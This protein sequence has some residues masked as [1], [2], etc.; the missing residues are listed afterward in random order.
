M[1]N[2]EHSSPV[3]PHSRED[4]AVSRR[5]VF[6]SALGGL[7]AIGLL[8][9]WQDPFSSTMGSSQQPNNLV[10][11]SMASPEVSRQTDTSVSSPGASPVALGGSEDRIGEIEV[12]R[13]ERFQY[14]MAPTDSDTLSV[15]ISG[16]TENLNF[17]PSAVRQDPQIT[18]SYLDPLVWID[19]VTMEP[20]P[21]LAESWEWSDDS[22]EITF[23]LRDDVRWHDG[24]PLNARDVAF[25]FEVYRDDVDSAVRN[26]FTQMKSAE[27]IDSLTVKIELITPDGNWV[28]NAASQFMFQRKQYVAHWESQAEGQRTLSRF[29]WETVPP[30]GTGPWIIGNRRSV[31]IEG[32]RNDQYWAEPPQYQNLHLLLEGSQEERL[33]AWNAGDADVLWPVNVD[34]LETVMDTPARLYA[35]H[36]ASVMFAAF[37]FDNQT[38]ALPGLLGDLRIREALSLAVDRERYATEVFRGFSLP[39]ASGTVAQPWAHD[40]DLTSP[41]RDVERARILLEEAGLTDLNGDG[42]LEDYNG[43]PL[44]FSAIARDDSNPLLIRLLTGLIDDFADLGVQMSVRVLS[45]DEFASSWIE[46][47]D[48]DFIAYSY[49]LYPG[50]TDWDL[51]G[52]NWDIRINPQGWNPGGYDNEDADSMIKRIQLTTDPERQREMLLRLQDTVNADLFGLWFGFPDDLVLTRPN[53]EGFQPNK[54][55]ATWNTRWLWDSAE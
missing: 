30:I 21:W 14:D 18:A 20:R 49:A 39:F 54:Y 32:E 41:E 44:A 28:R 36:G 6:G 5:A 11:G 24:D 8:S 31:R 46:R 2:S 38:R 43:G 53:I 3:D 50:F 4:S 47:R 9:R 1:P 26:L 17:S 35:S 13:G 40:F 37:N 27:A 19:D 15:S 45:P 16:G 51:Y 23:R 33:Q 10:A 29:T 34:E 48:Y 55:I 7:G 52:S 42:W 12:F 25:S 22:R